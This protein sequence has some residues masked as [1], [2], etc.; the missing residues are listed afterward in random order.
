MEQ[1]IIE[2]GVYA[3]YY[4]IIEIHKI[5]HLPLKSV[6]YKT[7]MQDVIGTIKDQKAWFNIYF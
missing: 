5:I 1:N 3:F 7:Q 6:I 4:F 2:K